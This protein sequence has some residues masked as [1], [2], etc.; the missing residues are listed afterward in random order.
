MHV[1]KPANCRQNQIRCPEGFANTSF[2]YG[3]SMS[4]TDTDTRMDGGCLF[5]ASPPTSGNKKAK[6]F[7]CTI[8]LTYTLWHSPLVLK[9]SEVQESLK[10][11]LMEFLCIIW[12]F[13]LGAIIMDS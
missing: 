1:F 4:K 8:Y 10:M 12:L 3:N 6:A 2:F 13:T 5:S 11:R 9:F 7:C